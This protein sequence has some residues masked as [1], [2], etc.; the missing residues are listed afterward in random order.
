[1][2]KAEA[3]KTI[4]ELEPEW[5]EQS[6]EFLDQMAKAV[7]VER[8]QPGDTDPLGRITDEQFER[9]IEAIKTLK[10]HD[11][12]MPGMKAPARHREQPSQEEV[13]NFD[14]NE[15]P[16]M[17]DKDWNLI[18]SAVSERIEDIEAW[19]LNNPTASAADQRLKHAEQENLLELWTRWGMVDNA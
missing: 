4:R 17:L 8:H 9:W 10:A 13:P 14:P 16:L 3:R 12:P 6:D 19:F 11:L 18:C 2:D 15:R 7:P 1:M 5:R